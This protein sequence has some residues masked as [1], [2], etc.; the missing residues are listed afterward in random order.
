[1]HH[2]A[3]PKNVL[4]PEPHGLLWAQT[5]IHHDHQDVTKSQF[6]AASQRSRWPSCA[7]QPGSLPSP[8]SRRGPEKPLP[9][10]PQGGRGLLGLR[11]PLRSARL[12]LLQ[13]LSDKGFQAIVIGAFPDKSDVPETF[14]PGSS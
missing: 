13:Q 3:A 4:P 11:P 2:V 8:P 5:C 10:S 7:P 1:M 12:S 6:F 14:R 9:L